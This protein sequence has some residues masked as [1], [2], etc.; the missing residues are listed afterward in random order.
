MSKK[1]FNL[2]LSFLVKLFLLL[3][4]LITDSCKKIIEEVY[5]DEK[6]I[7]IVEKIP[8]IQFINDK[9]I[10]EST[11]Y[12]K[13]F[14]K[15][16]EYTKFSFLETSIR[17]WNKNAFIPNSVKV[18]IVRDTRDIKTKTINAIVEFVSKGG[19]LVLLSTI[20]DK[21]FAYFMG[22]NPDANL[23]IDNTSKGVYFQKAVLP[24]LKGKKNALKTIHYGLARKNFVSDINVLA[25]SAT[26]M[27]YPVLLEHKIDN[28]N[29]I[30]YN[31]TNTLTKRDRGL[32][33][34]MIIKG[35][36]GVPYPIANVSTIFIDDFPSPLYDSKNEPIK[37]EMGIS[38][39]DFVTKVWWQDMLALSKEFNIDYTA[40]VAFEYSDN[41]LPP[42]AFEQWDL[43]S[44]KGDVLG[45]NW[46]AEEVLNKG[47]ELGLHGYNHVSLLLNDWKNVDYMGM[48]LE[49][50]KKKWKIS[51]L[52][53][54][55]ISYVPPSNYIDSIGLNKLVKVIPSIK[56]MCSL[57]LGSYAEGNGREYDTDKLNKYLFDYPRISSGYVIEN[58]KDY[59]IQ[60][61]YLYTGIWS[62][63]VHPDDVYQIKSEKNTSSGHFEYRN[64]YNLFW[65]KSINDKEGMFTTFK[66]YL[67]EFQEIYP[68]N[69]YL[70][71]DDASLNVKKWRRSHYFNR[72][73]GNR[74]IVEKLEIKDSTKEHF[75]FMYV[76]YSNSAKMDTSLNNEGIEYHKTEY[77]EGY[78]YSLKTNRKAISVIN[79]EPTKN[80][81]IQTPS[82]NYTAFYKRRA[83]ILAIDY[84]IQEYIQEDNLGAAILNLKNRMDTNSI[85]KPEVWNAYI[86]LNNWEEIEIDIWDSLDEHFIKYPY[87]ENL[88]YA[89]KLSNVIGYK[90]EEASKKWL[91]REIKLFPNAIGPI[92]K[93][94]KMFSSEKNKDEIIGLLEKLVTLEPNKKNHEQYIQYLLWYMPNSIVFKLN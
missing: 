32:L 6:E 67:K 42:F 58:E 93:Y 54:L 82:E 73:E 38:N 31:S 18:L 60:S 12:A 59:D 17:D 4:A 13:H 30:L 25:T 27:E 76:G 80:L 83:E 23:E 78:L 1:I 63:F 56:Y 8:Q 21:R 7:S 91:S 10:T 16:C 11:S 14:Q 84:M 86:K 87:P 9:E 50:A 74:Y 89:K 24:N 66:N 69:R 29:V 72:K 61:L 85:I 20:E 44:Q 88:I 55:P 15:I 28:G 53:K 40:L 41:T 70:N 79:L 94:I 48:S 19:S 81:K 3:I 22:V 77:L 37:S 5:V 33:F 57:Y 35:L 39:R 75:W 34:S 68:F 46:M 62:H 64:K 90:N 2:S 45:S 71:A 65:R 43:N 49:A 52:G 26:N 51:Q 36:E 47:H 92:K